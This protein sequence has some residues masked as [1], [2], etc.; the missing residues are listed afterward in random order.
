MSPGIDVSKLPKGT[1]LLVKTRNSLYIIE[2]LDYGTK[3][4]VKGGR[5]FP[6]HTEAYFP[7]STY[8]GAHMKLNWINYGM[9]M[10][11]YTPNKTIITTGVRNATILAP[12]Y[13]YTMNWEDDSQIS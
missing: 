1:K 13:N 2:K 10:E 9:H 6:E 12:N 8:G 7:G 3:V 5:H 4:L 11:F